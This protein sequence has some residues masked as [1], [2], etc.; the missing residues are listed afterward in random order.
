M[1]KVRIRVRLWLKEGRCARWEAGLR[2]AYARGGTSPT[3]DSALYPL[4]FITARQYV[5]ASSLSSH[6]HQSR[7]HQQQKRHLMR[8]REALLN[9]ILFS[10]GVE[11]CD[12]SVCLFVCLSLCVLFYKLYMGNNSLNIYYDDEVCPEV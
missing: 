11:Y 2:R 5:Y 6:H 1:V 9:A 7:Q 12:E 8:Q 4:I 3:F 10:R